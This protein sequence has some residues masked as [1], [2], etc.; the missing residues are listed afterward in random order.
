MLKKIIPAVSIGVCYVVLSLLI[1]ESHP[2]SRELMYDS[3]PDR[4]Y[5]FYLSDTHG[6][7]LPLKKFYHFTTN[8]LTHVYNA[9][10]ESR[11]LNGEKEAEQ[12]QSIGKTMMEELSRRRFADVHTDSIQLHQINYFLQKDSI[13]TNDIM[14]YETGSR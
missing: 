1:G 9:I 5:T 12:H 2:F 4:S 3:F 10:C 8:E 14:M 6:Q 11:D 13:Q 7:L